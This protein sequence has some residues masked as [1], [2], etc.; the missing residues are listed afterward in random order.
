MY[1]LFYCTQLT[2]QVFCILL[3]MIPLALCLVNLY[4]GRRAHSYKKRLALA[5]RETETEFTSFKAAIHQELR[6]YESRC[7]DHTRTKPSE[8]SSETSFSGKRR[9]TVNH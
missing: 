6:G 4:T 5:I 3:Y 1:C 8:K 2:L 7:H 9:Q